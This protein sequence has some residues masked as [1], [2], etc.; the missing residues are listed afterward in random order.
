M[1]V[2]NDE[3]SHT[4]IHVEVELEIWGE[5]KGVLGQVEEVNWELVEAVDLLP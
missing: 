4:V 3:L 2:S 1:G 5:N